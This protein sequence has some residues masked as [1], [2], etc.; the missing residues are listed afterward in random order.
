MPKRWEG[1]YLHTGDVGHIDEATLMITDR[2]KD[3]IK[4]ARMGVPLKLV[5]PLPLTGLPR[6]RLS[7]FPMKMGNDRFC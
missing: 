4:S 1:D 2:M 3:V 6:W 7:V 5:W